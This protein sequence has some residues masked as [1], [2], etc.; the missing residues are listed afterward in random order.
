MKTI[1]IVGSRQIENP[2]ETIHNTN[3]TEEKIRNFLRDILTDEISQVV[4]GGAKG[5]DKIAEEEAKAL[6]I[7]VL[8][9]RPEDP[10]KKQ[11][12]ILRNF[13]IV[14]LSDEVYVFWNGKSKGTKSVMKYAVKV[15]KNLNIIR[16]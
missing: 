16:I 6:N 7:P 3:F 5:V 14:D 12:Y 9:I 4:T 13:K 2:M 8:V 10:S 15:K 1:A 11:D